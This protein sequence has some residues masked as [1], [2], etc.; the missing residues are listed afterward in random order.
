MFF[1]IEGWVLGCILL[2]LCVTGG[3]R[4]VH[5]EVCDLL[6]E[7][8]ARTNGTHTDRGAARNQRKVAAESAQAARHGHERARG[9]RCH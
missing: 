3:C 5:R 4:L 7:I 8:Y 2:L 6:N 1:V 9:R